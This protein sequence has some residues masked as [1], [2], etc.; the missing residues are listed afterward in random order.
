MDLRRDGH[1]GYREG[2]ASRGVMS[3]A[4]EDDD[5]AELPAV[6]TLIPH[7]DLTTEEWARHQGF[8]LVLGQHGAEVGPS[9][10]QDRLLNYA[11][12]RRSVAH[13]SRTSFRGGYDWC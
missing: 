6:P 13:L 11:T 3:A 4:D 7:A 8:M 10:P 12:F 2:R 5:A 1:H 9:T